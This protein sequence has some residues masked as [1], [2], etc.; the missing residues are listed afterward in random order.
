MKWLV[1]EIIKQK[2]WTDTLY[3]LYLN[4]KNTKL[5]FSAGQFVQ[6]T[7]PAASQVFRPYSLVN[8]PSES[9]LEICYSSISSGKLTPVL[10]QLKAGEEVWVS[11][12]AAGRF[13]LTYIP[14][15]EI[16]WLIAT[17]TG[18]GP[19][20]SMLKT[21]EPWEKF[22]KIVLVHSVRYRQELI[23]EEYAKQWQA[24]RPQQ[25]YW[26]PVVT[27][28]V[29]TSFSKRLAELIR[30]KQIENSLSLSLTPENSQVMLCGNPAM[31]TEV[32]ETLL[33]RKLAIRHNMQGH[34]TLE[35]YWK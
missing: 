13:V 5:S 34:I 14:K 4:L 12:K 22:S 26:V 17:G 28:E 7:L 21:I 2:A 15:S 25:F 18:I 3:T 10:T 27:G 31:V 29:T 1:A 16:I 32:V 19:Y 35:S 11:E 30:T 23:Y 6:L 33:T 9:T 20:I 24:A 8:A